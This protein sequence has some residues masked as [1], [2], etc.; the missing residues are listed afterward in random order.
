MKCLEGECIPDYMVEVNS[1]Q[2]KIE[3]PPPSDTDGDGIPD[4][5][6]ACYN[7]GCKIVDSQG[8]PKDSDGDGVN[9]CDDECPNEAGE[10]TNKG[11]PKKVIVSIEICSVNY[12][13]P[14]NDN[15]NLNKEWVRICNTGNQDVNMSGWKLYDDSYRLG[16]ARDHIFYFPS[17]FL[18]KAGQSVTIYTGSG[19]NTTSKLYWGRKEGEDIGE[20]AIW[21]ND[22]DCAYLVDEQGDVVDTYC[23]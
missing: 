20:G 15:Y 22:G 18:L 19:I 11:C 14:G 21:N 9:D 10:K 5:E 17:G 23:W 16:R 7:P 4:D 1:E 6:D 13:A 12:D 3:T 8:C 2:C